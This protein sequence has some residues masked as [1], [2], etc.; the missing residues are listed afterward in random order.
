MVLLSFLILGASFILLG[1]TFLVSDKK[2]DMTANAEAAARAAGAMSVSGELNGWDLRVIISSMSRSSGNHIFI[3]DR[4]G[5]VVSCSDAEMPCGHIGKNVSEQTM[6]TLRAEGE[7]DQI[8][9]LD[10]FYSGPYYVIAKPIPD[11]LSDGGEALG[12]VFVGHNSSGLVE[13]WSAFIMVFFAVAMAVLILALALSYYM[14]KRQAKP[15][16]EMA[17]AATRFAHG[18]FSVRVEEEEDRDD[19]IGALTQAFNKMADSLE[20]A[21][22]QRREFIANVSHELKTPM[23]AIAGFADGI[24]DGTI[25]PESQAKYLATISSETKRLARLVRRMLDLS[26]LQSK[27]LAELRSQDFDV[28]EL[29]LKTLLNFENKINGKNLDVNAQLPESGVRVLGDE[30][31][32]NQVVYNLLDNA[33]KFAEPGSELS[34]SLWKQDGKAFVCIKNKG[35]TIA[36]E[37]IKR[38]FDRFHKTDRS[39]SMDRDGVGLGLYIVKTI[40]DQHGEEIWVTSDNG[41]TSFTFTLTT[42]GQ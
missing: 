14:S 23:T 5:R 19:E 9:M 42:K 37:D 29:L 18:N 31:A 22:E 33:V 24:L 12:Y 30:D 39:R 25:P 7:L 28:N 11:M 32:I 35:E 36:H 15:I 41:I 3:C 2:E 13:A 40:I 27:S 10:G 6:E 1:R 26:P 38:I 21:E 16:N 20:A 4:D 34:V 8:T 17:A